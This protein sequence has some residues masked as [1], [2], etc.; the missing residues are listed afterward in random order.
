MKEESVVCKNC[1]SSKI[2]VGETSGIAAVRDIRSKT[3]LGGS[4]LRIYFCE[5][6]GMV[7]EMYVENPD[8]IK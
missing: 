8:A 2:K 3:G 6:C 5:R 1:N 4:E 7:V